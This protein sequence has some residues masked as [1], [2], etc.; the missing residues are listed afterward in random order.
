MVRF[1]SRLAADTRLQA[2]PG[3][4]PEKKKRPSDAKESVGVFHILLVSST[5]FTKS[6]LVQADFLGGITVHSRRAVI[7][8][9]DKGEFSSNLISDVPC[10][11]NRA[12]VL[13]GGI[14]PPRYE[15]RCIVPGNL[16]EMS[17][18]QML[19][20]QTDPLKLRPLPVVS[21]SSLKLGG[22]SH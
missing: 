21:A 16:D 19:F 3:L 1:S 8:R 10:V 13:E 22:A 2:V 11:L 9:D 20:R 14:S 6:L 12:W 18:M 15:L 7:P 17:Y 5:S 4:T